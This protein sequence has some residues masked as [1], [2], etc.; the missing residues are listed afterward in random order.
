LKLAL[1]KEKEAMEL[2]TQFAQ[3]HTVARDIFEFLIGEETK[4]KL[5]IEKKIV[6]LT[7]L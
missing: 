1:G 5:L 6:E 7:K 4:H 3:E 2:Y